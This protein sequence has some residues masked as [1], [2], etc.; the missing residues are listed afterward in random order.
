M[1]SPPIQ[2]LRISLKL[3][4]A[5]DTRTIL[6]NL[7]LDI[8]DLDKIRNISD[9]G[10]EQSDIQTLSGLTA[11]ID[12]DAVAIYNETLSYNELTGTLNDG[13]RIING[14][15][16]ISGQII[17]PSFKFK[18]IDFDAV[19]SP[20][21]RTVDFSTSRV[22][23]WSS[24]ADS[25]VSVFYGGDVIISSP[26]L[27]GARS[28]LELSSLQF[29]GPIKEKIYESE[30]PTH[31]IRVNID[32]NTYDLFAM[33]GIPLKFTG[34]F[35]S[36]APATIVAGT[37]VPA[38]FTIRFRSIGTPITPLNP[39]GIIRPTWVLKNTSNPNSKT[40]YENRFNSTATLTNPTESVGTI[41]TSDITFSDT[42]DAEREIEF[43]YPVNNIIE[44]FLNSA[45]IYD[46]PKVVLPFLTQLQII[47][48][49][50]IEMPD[51]KTLYPRLRF[52]TLNNN[53]LTR[54]N[55]VALRT[56][57]PAVTD[58]ISTSI[59]NINIRDGVYSGECTASLTSFPSLLSF[60]ASSINSLTRKMTGVS[61]A[62]GPNL[63]TYNVSYNRFSSIH[64]SV[65][66]S[67]NIVNIN[68]R[69]NYLTIPNEVNINPVVDTSQLTKIQFF[70]TGLNTHDVINMNN[71]ET[72][73]DYVTANMNFTG[74]RL[75]TNMIS[76][77][78]NLARFNIS[79][80]NVTGPLP[81]FSSNT[82]LSE[83]NAQNTAWQDANANYSIAENTFGDPAAAVRSSLTY[84]NLQSNRLRKPIHPNAFIDM[85]ALTTLILTSYG[86]GITGDY[87]ISLNRCYSLNTLYLNNNKLSGNL[88]TFTNFS[89]N[90]ALTLVNLSNNTLSG[91]FP[92]LDLPSLKTLDIRKNLFTNLGLLK[93]LS[94]TNL[95][96]SNNLLTEIP[97]FTNMPLI[98]EVYLNN[99][100]NITYTAERLRIATSLRILDLSNCGL[101]TGDI[102]TI[103][104]DLNVNYNTIPRSGVTIN[105]TS[106]APPSPTERI[107]SII[108]RLRRLGWTLGLD[109]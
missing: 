86:S 46:V 31:K 83:F 88:S 73:V 9:G 84:F 55:T 62:I 60:S 99:N 26:P 78:T 29:N 91:A 101:N 57:S 28:S 70:S 34:F 66:E 90:K 106:N 32:S 85:T 4:D 105:L 69:A 75:G 45:R 104:E 7:N 102:D 93:C 56:F 87:P 40:V 81:D 6:K 11:D 64:P 43:Y 53:D 107:T 30:V 27:P 15:L 68:I 51:L 89:N 108:N 67:N 3:A 109:T 77:C 2:G 36:L 76:G 54:S 22:S 74:D 50:L 1:A 8:S 24:F 59:V 103:L 92:P 44:I 38:N 63:Q 80:T 13:R 58:R 49:D 61:P 41:K 18:K 17:A 94:L 98:Q 72:L 12:K 5:L 20:E 39:T 48:G 95:N 23:A 21:I 16:D 33:K 71:R 10:V 65:F 14:N 100:P 82:K 47:D 97:I 37:I 96:I 79:S 25:S 52:L 35:R 42:T 19:P